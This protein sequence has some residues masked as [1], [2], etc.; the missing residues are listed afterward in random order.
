MNVKLVKVSMTPPPGLEALLAQLW[1]GENGF[2]GTGQPVS[3]ET[4]ESYLRGLVDMD[5]GLN[6]R[7]GWVPM[8]THWL[9]DG[10]ERIVGVSRLRHRLTPALLEDGGH[11]GYY[12]LPPERGKGYGTAILRLTLIEARRLGI[13]RALL[14]VDSDNTPSIRVIEANAGV[15][16]DE[17]VDE[18]GTPYRRYWIDLSSAPDEPPP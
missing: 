12:V 10:E 18:N 9:L 3:T 4:L 14:T 2:V 7:D 11:I 6:L 5:Q 16:E 17:R 13:E 8:T 1:R 15:L